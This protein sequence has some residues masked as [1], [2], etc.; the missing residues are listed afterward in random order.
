MSSQRPHASTPASPPDPELAPFGVVTPV[1]LDYAPE[2][3]GEVQPPPGR[4]AKNGLLGR[5]AR[6]IGLDRAIAFTVMARGWSALS[7]ALTITLVLRTLTRVQQGYWGVINPLV[8]VQIIFELGFSFVIL[9]TASHECAYL[10]IDRD[11]TIHGPAREQGRLASILQK[12]LRWYSV[13]AVLLLAFLLAAG[14]HFFAVVSARNPTP[15]P[16]HW[17]GPWIL[18]AIAASFTFQIDPIFSFLEGCGFVAEVARAR[19]TQFV[20]GSLMSLTALLLHHGLYAPGCMLLG[21]ALAGFWAIGGHRRLLLNVLRHDP[22]QHRTP[23]RVDIWPLQWRMAVSWICGYATVPLFVPVLMGSRAWGPIEAGKMA[24]SISVAG[25]I[26]DVS[27]A[28]MNTKSAPFGRLIALGQF[29][30]LD[31]RFF[32]SLVQSSGIGLL[33]AVS[34]WV[35]AVLLERSGSGYATRFLPP[36]GLALL[37]FGYVANAVVSSMALYL[38]AHKQEK[39]MVNSI[40]GAIYSA[41]M[42]WILGH[43]FG[44]MGIAAGYAVGS[45]V[46]G[47]GYGTYTFLRWRRIWHGTPAKAVA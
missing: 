16:I 10:R 14:H 45:L 28:W 13:A 5:A 27:M 46:I 15:E 38:R 12:A 22:G 33:G 7:A 24:I 44:G 17:L 2:G 18:A 32:R 47:L 8:G 21:Q 30:E 1:P 11:G 36:M 6:F 29:G 9:Q 19:F 40:L 4:L 42:A 25:K 34:V 35:L 31:N 41:P 23:F 37:L 3:T 39:F 26:A 43:R 20:T